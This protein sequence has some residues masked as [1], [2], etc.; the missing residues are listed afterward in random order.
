LNKKIDKKSKSKRAYIAWDVND[1]PSSSSST[2][3][4]EEAKLCF[5]TK[6]ESEN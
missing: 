3:E 4:E 2:S 1:V 5:M 6:Q